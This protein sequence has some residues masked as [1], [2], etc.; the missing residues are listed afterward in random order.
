MVFHGFL[1]G[2]MSFLLI[3][4][5][6]VVLFLIYRVY[7]NPPANKEVKYKLSLIKENLAKRGY[8]TWYFICSGK[9]SVWY[10]DLIGGKKKSFHLQGKAIDI[11]VFDINGD[12]VFDQQDITV[13]EKINALVEKEHPELTGA[14]GTYRKEGGLN[15]FMVHL[16]TRGRKVRYDD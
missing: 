16:D 9:R 2:S 13:L 1:R 14:F 12:W 8:R 15:G 10:N 7:I 11:I 5:A 4:G 3:F 6:M